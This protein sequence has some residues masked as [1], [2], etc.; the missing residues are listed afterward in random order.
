MKCIK[1]HREIKERKEE[2]TR[3]NI[4]FLATC[5]SC[6]IHYELVCTPFQL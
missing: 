1:C 5:I 6:G 4:S 2:N 3:N